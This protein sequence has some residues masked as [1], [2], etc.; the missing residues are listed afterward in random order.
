MPHGP[1][2]HLCAWCKK[3][4]LPTESTECGGCGLFFHVQW[5]L[6][7]EGRIPVRPADCYQSHLALVRSSHRPGRER[8]PQDCLH[9]EELRYQASTPLPSA[10]GCVV[11]HRLFHAPG[12]AGGPSAR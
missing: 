8:D 7:D 6:D 10:S 1:G 5:T 3:L 4:A 9:A 12:F 2:E 11:H